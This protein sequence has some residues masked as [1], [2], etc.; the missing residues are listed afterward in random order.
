MKPREVVGQRVERVAGQV[1]DLERVGE[2]VDLRRQLAQVCTK[3]Q[4]PRSLQGATAKLLEGVERGGHRVL[5][6]PFFLR[7][8]LVAAAFLEEGPELL[9]IAGDV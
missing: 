6:G 2:R 9:P 8:R 7:P 3:R 5:A 4:A 1:E